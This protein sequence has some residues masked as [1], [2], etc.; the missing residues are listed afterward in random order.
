MF[1]FF[2]CLSFIH[3]LKFCLSI[4]P[5]EF[6]SLQLLFFNFPLHPPCP[7][8]VSLFSFICS[9]LFSFSPVCS[10][11]YQRQTQGQCH[12]ECCLALDESNSITSSSLSVFVAL[13]YLYHSLMSSYLVCVLFN[14][15]SFTLNALWQG[16]GPL[17]ENE[18]WKWRFSPEGIWSVSRKWIKRLHWRNLSS[19]QIGF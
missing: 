13:R 3:N 12:R 14:L 18:L 7:C 5:D 15:F 8:I 19:P 16:I 4:A 11:V 9:F 1:S 6:L 10:A 2:F 17:F